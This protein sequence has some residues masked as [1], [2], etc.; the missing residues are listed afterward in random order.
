MT[1]EPE[2]G[3]RK[4]GNSKELWQIKRDGEYKLPIYSIKELEK[5]IDEA[6]Q[7]GRQ[8]YAKKLNNIIDNLQVTVDLTNAAIKRNN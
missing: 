4:M 7:S 8:L 5:I 6:Y 3:K 1:G 2:G